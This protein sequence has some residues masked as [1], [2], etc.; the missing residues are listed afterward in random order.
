MFLK[1]L[2]RSA[3][4]G[5]LSFSAVRS[6]AR[7]LAARGLFP[8]RLWSGYP[9]REVIDYRLD[10]S[11][12]RYE[13]IPGDYV[14]MPIYWR[15]ADAYEPETVQAFAKLARNARVF[16]DIGASTGLFSLIA[17]SVNPNLRAWAFEPLP[18][19]YN[20]LVRNIGLNDFA[21]RVQAVNAA[22]GKAPG[23]APFFVPEGVLPMSASLSA[24][25]MGGP[26]RIDVAVDTIDDFCRTHPTPDLVKIDV[27][28]LEH[29]VLE[30]M[31]GVIQ[32]RRPALILEI[33]HDAPFAALHDLL[34]G[35]RFGRISA[36]G[37]QWRDALEPPGGAS[38]RNWL[39]VSA[40]SAAAPSNRAAG[41]SE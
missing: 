17:A 9:V 38:E 26:R 3:L 31:R 14:G 12:F 1:R 2:G 8:Q 7:A 4:N 23:T 36:A 16:F 6:P 41:R 39:C 34:A 30:G 33:L 20:Q 15:G 21:G 24:A 18:Q 10:Q 5:L 32:Q 29:E 27:E 28:G 37:I 22:I 40:E 35:Y 19:A 13:V 11:N 25:G